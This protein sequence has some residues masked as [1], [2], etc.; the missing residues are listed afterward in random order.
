LPSFD[1]SRPCSC[2]SRIFRGCS[3][4]VPGSSDSYE[5][6]LAAV[7]AFHE[8]RRFRETGGE[9]MRKLHER[10]S[11][12]INGRIRVSEYRNSDWYGA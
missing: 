5:A 10:E 11:R 4:L 7:R 9:E 1:R 3:N 6:M 8:K 12:M 2:G